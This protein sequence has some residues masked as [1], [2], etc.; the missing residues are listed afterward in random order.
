MTNS[1][2]DT[3][4]LCALG[5]AVLERGPGR[6]L[7]V[8]GT[9]PAWVGNLLPSGGPHI[10]CQEVVLSSPFLADFF[11]EAEEFWNGAGTI[12]ESGT[13]SQ[14]NLNGEETA[15]EAWA[16][17]SGNRKFLM[18]K[19]LE[20]FEQQRAV[21]QKLCD[22]A[23]L[24][25][26]LGRKHRELSEAKNALEIQNR[27]VERVNEL[28]TEFLSSMSHELR[29]P[30]NAIVG[31]SKLLEEES[32][33]TLNTEQRNYV[34]H[35]ATASHHLL[36][37]INEILDLAKIEAG[38]LELEPERFTFSEALTEVLATIRPLARAKTINV[39]TKL[40]PD[41]V[42]YADRLRFKQILFNL[43]SNA[44]KF[45]PNFGE[46]AI[47]CSRD[48]ASTIVVLTDNGI[49]VP[50]EEQDAIFEKFHQALPSTSGVKEGTGLGLAITRRL[51]EQ[52]GGRIWV[53]SAPGLGARFS[54][55]L[56]RQSAAA[57]RLAGDISDG[58]GITEFGKC[59]SEGLKI[60]VVEQNAAS[61]AHEVQSLDETSRNR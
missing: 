27:E 61:S 17:R 48:D 41:D 53:E 18:V 58:D 43:L 24:N 8:I 1:E 6:V 59:Q 34:R 5:I 40:C 39:A 38:R 37:L 14:R 20:N 22:V 57:Q 3:P 32:A 25:E 11:Q 46:I 33:A 21:F 9:P 50:A 35:I 42:I 47:E 36:A 56:P 29:T 31:F 7:S 60:G 15:F 23:L 54:F 45:T 4:L 10:T 26:S 13:W 52:H 49:G 44:I 28:K 51:V 55:S 16:L 12:L 2:N 30:L 19:L